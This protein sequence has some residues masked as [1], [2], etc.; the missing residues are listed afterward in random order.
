M[1]RYRTKVTKDGVQRVPIEEP[2]HETGNA[3]LG[4]RTAL[5]RLRAMREGEPAKIHTIEYGGE[6]WYLK[7]FDWNDSTLVGVLLG[8]EGVRFNDK[9]A[10]ESVGEA[11]GRKLTVIEAFTA[12]VLHVGVVCG[13]EG[14]LSNTPYFGLDVAREYARVRSLDGR[15]LVSVLWNK[16]TDLNPDIVPLLAGMLS[17]QKPSEEQTA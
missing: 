10:L 12:V 9:G 16:L 7:T 1:A 15:A 11:T 14:V 8:R 4:G 17:S 2:L 13:E 5:E 6:T 3:P